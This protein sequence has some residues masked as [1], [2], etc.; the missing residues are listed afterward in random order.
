M[1]RLLLSAVLCALALGSAPL[2]SQSIKPVPVIPRAQQTCLV[3]EFQSPDSV[4]FGTTIARLAATAVFR[5]MD[6]EV[7]VRFV[8]LPG[9]QQDQVV[10]VDS[11][12]K[13]AERVHAVFLLSG[14]YF[15]DADRVVIYPRVTC[16]AASG[17]NDSTFGLDYASE[18]GSLKARPAATDLTFQPMSLPLASVNAAGGLALR[19]DASETASES[20]AL[21]ERSAYTIT[22]MRGE[23]VKMV[24]EGGAG[25]WMH[26]LSESAQL[27]LGVFDPATDLMA[28]M[29]RFVAGEYRE[30]D[31]KMTKW[32]GVTRPNE[33]RMSVMF[34][35]LLAGTARMRT[36]PNPLI[37]PPDE[38]ITTAYR[39]ALNIVPDHPSPIDYLT[40]A[41]LAKHIGPSKDV[42]LGRTPDLV[43][44]EELMVE[45][46]R[47]NWNEL[48]IQNLQTFYQLAGQ[49]HFLK[50][51]E[52]DDTLY[53]K[54]LNTQLGTLTESQE[55][56]RPGSGRVIIILSPNRGAS[57]GTTS[58][59]FGFWYPK[60]K[61]LP[62][63]NIEKIGLEEF[64]AQLELSQ[65]F[66]LDFHIR[67]RIF[68]PLYFDFS[69]SGWFSQYK[70]KVTEEQPDSSNLLSMNSWALVLPITAGV[71]VTLLPDNP[72]HP[73][74]TA[75]GGA[76]VAFESRT[77][78]PVSFREFV[79]DD[80]DVL[81]A[82]GA[83]AGAGVD[84]LFSRSF[85]LSVGLKYQIVKFKEKLFSGQQDLTG[86]QI[87]AGIVT[88][89]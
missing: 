83:Y 87:L 77:Y 58:F 48:S 31:A 32:L 82:F 33:D 79:D 6:G 17:V 47:Q 89:L 13:I 80:T 7:P 72:I 63:R 14:D 25:G 29:S 60:D 8:P 4:A 24:P 53:T 1:K 46:I 10:G 61:E 71:S 69:F 54:Q 38:G 45:N 78:T 23:W 9:R 66:G 73:Y 51:K 11:L 2:H 59:R 12:T 18:Y 35:Y 70:Y 84:I 26:A 75:G 56:I 81:F 68:H 57:P 88:N 21:D 22:G 36:L 74:F 64:K 20:G 34:A 52:V 76:Y 43:E 86:V 40:I 44:S 27:P 19:S 37:F 62:F 28:A 67:N 39:A 55:Q 3:S 85:G 15:V 65:A 30:S 5:A 49:H 42:N 41:R 16:I 50:T